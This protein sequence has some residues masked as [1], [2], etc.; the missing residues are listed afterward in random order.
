LLKAFCEKKSRRDFY[1][2]S[3]VCA[4]ACMP[5]VFLIQIRSTVPELFRVLRW[6]SEHVMSFRFLVHE[7]TG[8]VAT[9]IHVHNVEFRKKQANNTNHTPRFSL[10]PSET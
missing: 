9:K 8:I 5:S 10:F 6:D 4:R 1:P 2:K 3:P 7:K